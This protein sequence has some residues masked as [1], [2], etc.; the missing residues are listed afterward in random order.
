MAADAP[1]GIVL[2]LQRMSTDDGPGIRTT[3]FLKGCSLSCSWCHNPESIDLA[4]RVV[5]NGERCMGCHTCVGVCPEQGITEGPERLELDPERCRL[6]DTCTDECPTGAMELLGKRWSVDDL[7][8]ELAKD[9]A[10]YDQSGGGVTLSG[11]EPALQ[12]EFVAAVLDA[13][14]AEGLHTTLDTCGMCSERRLRELATRADL[15]LFDLKLMDPAAHREHA[16]QTNERILDNARA[17]GQLVA[18]GPRPAGVWVRTPLIPGVTDGDD[19]VR[20]VGGFIA[21]AL[22]GAVHRYLSGLTFDGATAGRAYVAH[23]DAVRRAVDDLADRMRRWSRASAEIAAA[24]RA[25]ADRY[26]Q[27]DALAARRVG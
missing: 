17:L 24:L 25:S 15:V 1:E 27:A 10:Y 2:T 13:C 11:G 3:V 7:V 6:C 16:G 8:R 18:A 23:G 22:D 19:N 26:D 5:W 9:R 4:P 20:A 12:T 14:R 21:D